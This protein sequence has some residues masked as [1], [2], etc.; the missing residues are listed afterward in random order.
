[1]KRAFKTFEREIENCSQDLGE[2]AAIRAL[3]VFSKALYWLRKWGH[4][5][6]VLSAVD[7]N[8]GLK[9]RADTVLSVKDN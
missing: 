6:L 9:I 4:G 5:N 2:S 3:L 1:M 7:H 8:F